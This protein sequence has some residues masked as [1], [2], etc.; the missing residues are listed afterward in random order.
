MR[1]SFEQLKAEEEE[2][3]KQCA[4]LERLL[5]QD[6]LSF[7]NE[8]LEVQ[9]LQ[10]QDDHAQLREELRGTR[11]FYGR[12]IADMTNQL[13]ERARTTSTAEGHADCL[14]DLLLFHEDGGRRPTQPT[15]V[16]NHEHFRIIRLWHYA[17]VESKS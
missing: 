17:R 12:R 3:Q 8:A 4:E 14:S 5:R 7:E 1:Q 16:E 10:I 6:A 15:C 9:L 13:E 11:E 2:L